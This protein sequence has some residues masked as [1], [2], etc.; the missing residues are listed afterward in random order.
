MKYKMVISYDGTKYCG[1]QIQP[2]GLSIQEVCEAA[3]SEVLGGEAVR[4]HAAGRTDAGVHAL[5]QVVGFEC[6]LVDDADTQI[7]PIRLRSVRSMDAPE[8]RGRTTIYPH[9]LAVR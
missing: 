8:L 7:T 2:N 4:L 6:C 9:E 3:L 1:W 5:E